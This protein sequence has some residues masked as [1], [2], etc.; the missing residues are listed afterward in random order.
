MDNAEIS[1]AISPDVFLFFLT[2]SRLIDK[3]GKI[4]EWMQ[5]QPEARIILKQEESE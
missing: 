5:P 3:R 1:F 4:V 2:C